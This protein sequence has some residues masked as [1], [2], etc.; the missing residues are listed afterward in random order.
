MCY[1]TYMYVYSLAV[2]VGVVNTLGHSPFFLTN[3]HFHHDLII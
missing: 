3:V 1:Y 2:V